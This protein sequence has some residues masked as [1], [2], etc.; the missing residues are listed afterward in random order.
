MFRTT[1]VR[2]PTFVTN[3]RAIKTAVLAEHGQTVV[4]GGLIADNT[5]LSRQVFPI[6]DIPIPCLFRAD[7]RSNEKTQ[8]TGVYPSNH[9][10]RC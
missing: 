3:K 9:C 5:A 10:R 6:E 1:K 2:Q 4:L 7:S 8:P